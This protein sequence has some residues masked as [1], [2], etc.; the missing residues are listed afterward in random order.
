[1]RLISTVKNC[2]RICSPDYRRI[3]HTMQEYY[4]C[5]IYSALIF[6][7]VSGWNITI[8]IGGYSRKPVK[9]ITI[10]RGNKRVFELKRDGE[11]S[12]MSV[13]IIQEI[14]WTK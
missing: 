5:L 8:G 6:A 7:L 9:S 1:L 14:T 3:E 11:F 4:F 13:L 12:G 2:K 10:Q